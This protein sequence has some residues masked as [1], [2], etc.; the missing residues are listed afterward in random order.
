MALANDDI[1]RMCV[2]LLG[3]E[4]TGANSIA[5]A[6]ALKLMESVIGYLNY[7]CDG[8]S[9]NPPFGLVI[10]MLLLSKDGAADMDRNALDILMLGDGQRVVSDGEDVRAATSDGYEGW[11]VSRRDGDVLA[12]I[13]SD[14]GF[15]IVS[16]TD[17]LTLVDMAVRTSVRAY[18]PECVSSSQDVKSDICDA[19]MRLLV[20]NL[21]GLASGSSATRDLALFGEDSVFSMLC[22]VMGSERDGRQDGSYEGM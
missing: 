2:C 3:F 11:I 7:Y 17:Y 12:A 14:E 8:D 16:Y 21:I 20:E 5:E 1:K 9:E 13:R 4:R 6:A 22:S 15:P 10:D 19:A 18:G